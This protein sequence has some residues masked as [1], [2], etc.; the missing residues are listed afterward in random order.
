MSATAAMA[1]TTIVIRCLM[2][3]GPRRAFGIAPWIVRSES[4][5]HAH[6]FLIRRNHFVA[7]LHEHVELQ[8]GALRGQNSGVQFVGFT[9]EKTLTAAFAL[10]WVVDTC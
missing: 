10:F 3:R 7:D 5:L 2:L 4:D 6:D 1:M 9:G 8:I